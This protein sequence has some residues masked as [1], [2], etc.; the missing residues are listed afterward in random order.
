MAMPNF[1]FFFIWRPRMTVQG[2]IAKHRSMMPEKAAE[3]Y[4]VSP[5]ISLEE[6]RRIKAIPLTKIPNLMVIHL[7][8]HTPGVVG[9]HAV[10]SG[11]QLIQKNI[12]PKPKKMFIR[13]IAVQRRYFCQPVEICS[14][15]SAKE[16]LLNDWPTMEKV[17][18]MRPE[19]ARES[20][21][22][23]STIQMCWP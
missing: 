14:R 2:K 5:R 7:S 17:T 6:Y 3:G 20:A 9:F 22:W 10:S 12:A 21:F 8:Q 11:L 4:H 1:S 18:E 16:T 15:V 23:G 19:R 13:I